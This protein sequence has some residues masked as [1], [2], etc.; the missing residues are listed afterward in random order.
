MKNIFQW[1]SLTGKFLLFLLVTSVIP[2]FVVGLTSFEMSKTIIQDE[3]RQYTEA[4][5]VKQKDYMELLL[6]EVESLIANLSSIEDIKNV[7]VDKDAQTDDYTNLAT[8]AKIG[9]ILSGYSN[10]KGLC[11]LMFLH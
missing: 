1:H 6:E 2:L 11:L 8:Q 4:L 9:Y 5:M 10:L 3:V 7:V